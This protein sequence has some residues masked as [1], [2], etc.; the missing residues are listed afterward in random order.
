M[1]LEILKPKAAS[2]RVWSG[3]G[4]D[5]RATAGPSVGEGAWE[6]RVD[7]G[8]GYRVYFGKDGRSVVILLC[9]GSK[10][11]QR[12]DIAVAREFW[13]D[14]RRRKDAGKRSVR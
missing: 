4:W 10:A 13:R 1:L 5:C 7:S 12:K 14:Y 11:S 9:G 8:P 3:C 2:W 6:I